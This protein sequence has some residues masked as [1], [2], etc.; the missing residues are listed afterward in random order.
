MTI[1]F[2]KEYIEKIIC[3]EKTTTRRPKRPN[4]KPGGLYKI[5]RDFYNFL[6]NKIMVVKRYKQRLGDMTE[7]DAI[8]EGFSS[9]EEFRCEWN[10]IYKTWDPEQQVWVVEFRHIGVDRNP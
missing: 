2:K 7:Q 3:G 8:T 6:P 1:L 9:L 10:S 4:V 5:R